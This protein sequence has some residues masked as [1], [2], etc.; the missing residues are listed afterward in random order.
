MIS[1]F[2]L[3]KMFQIFIW[4]GNLK[5]PDYGTLVFFFNAFPPKK[6]LQTNQVCKLFPPLEIMFSH[7]YIKTTSFFLSGTPFTMNI[8]ILNVEKWNLIALRD[9]TN[10]YSHCHTSV[11]VLEKKRL[12]YPR[13]NKMNNEFLLHLRQRSVPVLYTHVILVLSLNLDKTKL[14]CE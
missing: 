7:L 9:E 10:P 12:I 4:S 14:H 5:M 8:V 1:L 13:W 2:F 3:N 6:T 11:S